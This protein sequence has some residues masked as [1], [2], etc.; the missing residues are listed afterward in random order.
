MLTVISDDILNTNKEFVI[1]Q[2]NCTTNQ[3]YG[4]SKS[5]KE[6]F[7]C[8]PY[9]DVTKN[10]TNTLGSITVHKTND[11]PDVICMYAQIY[12]G[13][14]EENTM[15]F[16][17]G[18]EQRL[19]WFNRCLD[20]I[21]NLNPKSFAV[22]FNIGCGGAGGNWKEDYFPALKRFS[23]RYPEIDMAVYCRDNLAC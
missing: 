17:D 14:P 6:R 19:E 16:G 8:D 15:F 9:K 10:I 12:K 21:K 3:V 4:L 7:G 13:P 23:E 11:G 5:I 18:R 1:Q 2:C 22:P 20:K